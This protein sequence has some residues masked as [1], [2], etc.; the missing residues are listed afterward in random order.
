MPGQGL[1]Q[2]LSIRWE[3]V[4]NTGS[5]GASNETGWMEGIEPGYALPHP[6]LRISSRYRVVPLWIESAL[7]LSCYW[8]LEAVSQFF[9]FVT[10][11]CS[12]L[13][14]I[15]RHYHHLLLPNVGNS[16]IPKLKA[17][18]KLE[19]QTAHCLILVS[20]HHWCST[21]LLQKNEEKSSTTN[22]QECT[23]QL[24]TWSLCASLRTLWVV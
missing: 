9:L 17:T 16:F 21:L 23:Q 20:F 8:L 11:Y 22:T 18:K 5:A 7:L 14:P 10:C 13:Y 12:F 15:R 2:W 24:S 1:N 3:E 4:T 19:L 6:P